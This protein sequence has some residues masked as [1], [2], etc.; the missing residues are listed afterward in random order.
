MSND[1][2][3]NYHIANIVKSAQKVSAW[4]LRTFL[5]R[6]RK[7]MKVLLQTILVHQLEYACVVWSPF[8]NKHINMIENVVRRFTSKISE[9]QSWDE[10]LQKNICTTNYVDRLKDLK[11]YSCE[12]RRE[13]FMILYA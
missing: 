9:Y 5:S 7:V 4:I 1:S 8:D 10:D 6:E 13:R 3:F 11:I 12:R 2:S